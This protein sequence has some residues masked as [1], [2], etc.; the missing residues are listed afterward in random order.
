[1]DKIMG[2]AAGG[3]RNVYI[4]EKSLYWEIL[5]SHYLVSYNYCLSV[6]SYVLWKNDDEEQ[7]VLAVKV[8][9]RFL[10]I[11]PYGFLGVCLVQFSSVVY[12]CAM[13]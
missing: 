8:T 4:F 5:P 6:K 2:L 13:F 1:M 3:R 10:S 9:L 11:L 7:R 12:M